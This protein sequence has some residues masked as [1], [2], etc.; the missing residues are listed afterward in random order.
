[1]Q[2]DAIQLARDAVQARMFA[3]ATQ[4]G[5][6]APDL[7]AMQP[8]RR[9]ARSLVPPRGPPGS[10]GATLNGAGI[11]VES[12]RRLEEEMCV[13]HDYA[14]AADCAGRREYVDSVVEAFGNPWAHLA[15]WQQQQQQKQQQQQEKKRA[16]AKERV[17]DEVL[18]GLTWRK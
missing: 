10:S 16:R 5:E 12:A 9:R 3:F 14:S 8:A 17:L 6:V 4:H 1:M 15:E 7:E 2:S 13:S 11:G 18:R